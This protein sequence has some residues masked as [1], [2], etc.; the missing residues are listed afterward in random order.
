MCGTACCAWGVPKHACKAHAVTF[1]PAV[2]L[3]GLAVCAAGGWLL[4][5]SLSWMAWMAVLSVLFIFAGD[6]FLG[7]REIVYLTKVC[8]A[9][10]H[11]WRRAS[12]LHVGGLRSLPVG[13]L[14]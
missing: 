7:L 4:A 2:T 10:A 9:R 8:N 1:A 12:G 13:L 14:V 6:T 3:V 11:G 5:S